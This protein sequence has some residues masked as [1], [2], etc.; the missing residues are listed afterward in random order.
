LFDVKIFVRHNGL[1]VEAWTR[2]DG[3]LWQAVMSA[4]RRSLLARP[5]RPQPPQVPRMSA[6]WL[7][8]H[9]IESGKHRDG[10]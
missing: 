5:R 8:Q 1:V 10:W 4:V 3:G 9:E 7:K 2:V 6:E